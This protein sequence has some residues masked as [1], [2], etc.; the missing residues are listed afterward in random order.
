MVQGSVL[1]SILYS[2]F[3]SPLLDLAKITLFTDDNYVMI[4]IKHRGELII[5]MTNKLEFITKWPSDSG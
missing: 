1:G 2:L 4:W 3:V 5:K